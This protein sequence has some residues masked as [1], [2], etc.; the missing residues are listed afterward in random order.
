M[1]V[2]PDENAN[3]K[4]HIAKISSESMIP[5]EKSTIQDILQ[6]NQKLLSRPVSDPLSNKQVMDQEINPSFCI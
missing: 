5:G 6:M 3:T 1:Q 4:V 2:S